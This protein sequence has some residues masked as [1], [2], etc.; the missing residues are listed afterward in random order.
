MLAV[1]R[2]RNLEFLRDR[3]ALAWN[4][5]LPVLIILG[6]AF[7]FTGDRLDLYKVGVYPG[8]PR[9]TGADQPAFLRTAHLQFLPVDDLHAGTIE[10]QRHQLDMLIDPGARRFWVNDSSPRGYILERVLRG[11]GGAAFEKQT[12]SGRPIRYV[13]WLVPGVLAMNMMFSALFGVGYVIVRYRKNGVLKRLSAT[14]LTALEFLAAQVVSRLWLIVAINVLVFVGTDLLVGF[15]MFGSYVDLLVVFT[16]GALSLV[17]LGLLVAA[18]TSSEELAGGLLNA[19]SWPMMFLSGVWFSPEGV[20]PWLRKLALVL[21]LTHVIDAARAIM[22]DGA[23]IAAVSG[24]LLVLLGMTAL[25][26]A[27]GA[28]FFRWQ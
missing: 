3:S 18:R 17:S 28:Y 13:D 16:V 11:T 15:A 6:F 24:H 23:G 10:V 25:F 14:P 12:L 4:V 19:I 5:L 9:Q 22:I 21:P 20:Y 1:L 8:V 7:A 26:L 2:T 27:I